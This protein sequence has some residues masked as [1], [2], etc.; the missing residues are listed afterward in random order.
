MRNKTGD[1]FRLQHILDAM[2]EI[3]SYLADTDIKGFMK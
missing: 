1:K 3:E 2:T